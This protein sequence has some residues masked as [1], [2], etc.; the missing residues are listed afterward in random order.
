M[1]GWGLNWFGGGGQKTKEAPKKAIL[2]LRGQLEMLN[3][4][5]KHL[6]NQMDEQDALARKYVSTNKNA[7]KQ[8]LR[9]KKQFEHSLEQT[10]A[11]IMT[12]ER[13]IY[14]IE[15]ANINK[16]TLDAMKNAGNAM[17]QI[18]AGLTIDKVDQTM[19]DLREQHAIGEEISEAITQSVGTQ[20]V[21]EDEL[22]EE[23]EQLQ[24]ESLDEQMLNTG[25]VPVGDKV[26]R[27]PTAAQHEPKGKQREEEDEEEELRKLQAEMA[28]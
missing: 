18:H 7:A 9:R 10:S 24:Q 3:K 27:L 2:Q 22:D 19:E 6:Q 15:T 4:R 21:D 14:S 12:L 16:E 8:A 5:E 20:G 1:S 26:G 13:E 17:K 23:L 28:M 11:Q 25:N